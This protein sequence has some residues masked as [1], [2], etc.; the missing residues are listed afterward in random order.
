MQLPKTTAL[1]AAALTLPAC[2]VDTLS[3]TSFEPGTT[4]VTSPSGQAKVTLVEQAGVTEGSSALRVDFAVDEQN[5]GIQI[6][7]NPGWETKDLGDCLLRFDAHNPG[8][9]SV[10]LT[11]VVKN[12]KGHSRRRVVSIPAGHTGSY[13]FELRSAD[14]EQDFGLRD[15]PP[16]FEI[17]ATKMPSNNWKYAVNYDTVSNISL[18]TGPL[19]HPKSLIIDNVRIEKSPTKDPD[20]L[21]GIVD[22]FGQN[23]SADF[24]EKVKTD[25]QLRELANQEL[26]ALAVSRGLPGRS[27]WGGW[28][29]GPKLKATGFFRTEKV[30][31]VWALVD[32]DGYLFFSSG[33][34]N[35]RMANTSTFTGVDFKDDSVRYIDPEDVTPEDSRGIVSVSDEVRATRYIINEQRHKL[36]AELPSYDDELADH[37]SYRRKTHHG[38][39]PHGETFTHYRANLERRYGETDPGS[40]LL[41][42]RDVT[43]DRMIDWGFTSFGNW[44]AAEFFHAKRV[45]YFANGWVIGDYATNKSGFDYWG[46][47]PDPFDLEFVRRANVTTKVVAEEVL[48]NPWCIG[49]FID[50]EM[51]WGK[52]DKPITQYGLVFSAISKPES[53]S[54]AKGAFMS[55][56]THKHGS[57]ESLNEAWGTGFKSWD[58]LADGVNLREAK[59][60]EGLVED[61]S[62]M[63][64]MYA[65][66]YFKVVDEALNAV[67]PNH[68]YMG[69][70]LATWGMT[71][72]VR[73][74]AKKHVDVMSY[75]YYKEG[76]GT[77]GWE[78]LAEMDMPSVIGEFH[79]GATDTGLFN[80]G[81]VHAADQKD[82]GRMWAEYMKS[83]ATNPH[84]VGA[85]WFQYIDS[86]LTG[87]AHD[88]ENYNVGWVTI[89]DVPYADMV[90]AAKAFHSDL[91]TMRFGQPSE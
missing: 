26:K 37:Y 48:G 13:Y 35:A 55:A 68:L 40:Y 59:H 8:D 1:L 28:K 62:M 54:P 66:E 85:H 16:A 4:D 73:R 41:K 53:E 81:L 18:T 67:L 64:E 50:N 14:L 65:T 3:I 27:V 34:A 33:I 19:L 44:A 58:E 42:W 70:R 78:F 11:T 36:F 31:G 2:A 24:L 38:P 91:Y 52:N 12:E 87:R 47:L 75:N 25:E 56:L 51:G 76:I 22:K 17:D 90:K 79:M 77:K 86:P 61:F 88:G 83:A 71:D 23:T 29:D 69:A 82:R 5:S 45:P 10:S 15:D 89:A 46:P 20:Y 39:V 9:Y 84:I 7:A 43:L 74:A 32:P 72:E 80:P 21:V 60:T 6:K 30:D 49:V 63:M 57:V